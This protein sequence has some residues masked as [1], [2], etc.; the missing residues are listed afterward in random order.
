[1]LQRNANCSDLS[2]Y[3]RLITALQVPHSCNPL[4]R[5]PTAAVS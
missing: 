3:D 4:W 1:M 5:I 2:G